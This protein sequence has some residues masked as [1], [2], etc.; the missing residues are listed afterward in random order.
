MDFEKKLEKLRKYCA[1]QDRCHFEVR[2]K[3]IALQVYGEDLERIIIELIKGNFLNEER[4]ARSYARGKFRMKK[5]G[6][7][8][9]IAELNQRQISDYCIKK[10]LEEIEDDEYDNV[11]RQIIIDRINQSEEKNKLLVKDEAIK[12]ANKRGY[13][14]VKIFAVI[15]ELE[16]S[17]N[18]PF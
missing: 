11:L 5:W 13:E 3:L 8:R 16:L 12:Y 4:F 15:K 2:N 6:K 7:K 14:A 9:I 17:S 10:G 18:N 1:Y